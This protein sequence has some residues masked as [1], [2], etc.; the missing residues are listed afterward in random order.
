MI[1][2]PISRSKSPMKLTVAL[3]FSF[4][5]QLYFSLGDSVLGGVLTSARAEAAPRDPKADSKAK[6]IKKTKNSKKKSAPTKKAVDYNA[7]G[8]AAFNKGN[9]SDALSKFDIATKKDPK[10]P[11]SWLNHARALVALNAASEPADY[12]DFER[13]WILGALSSLSSSW[14]LDRTKTGVMLAS[15]TDS[16]FKQFQSRPEYK[17]WIQLRRLPLKT[18]LAT[19]E[20]FAQNNDWLIPNSALPS[21]VVT[22]AP[23]HEFV[24]AKADG[25]RDVGRWSAGADRVIIKTKES[26]RT[27]NLTNSARAIGKSGRSYQ[28]VVLKDPTNGEMW[29]IGP[30]I[31]DCPQ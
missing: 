11:V 31:A 13:N 25:A 5:T 22:F 27:L 12:C 17:K 6:F 18:D 20:F 15:F 19:Q 16:S 1:S 4:V 29:S 2:R 8:V 14:M 7:P 3:T 10:N 9:F 26:Q 21:T 24:M 28:Q 23:S 30:E